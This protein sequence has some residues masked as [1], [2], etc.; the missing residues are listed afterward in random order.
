[1]KNKQTLHQKSDWVVPA[2]VTDM[3]KKNRDGIMTR[4]KTAAFAAMFE[5]Q[6]ANM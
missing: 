6:C 1:M 4:L 3:S 2:Y 5:S